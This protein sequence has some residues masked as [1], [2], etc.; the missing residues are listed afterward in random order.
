MVQNG[1]AMTDRCDQE[2]TNEVLASANLGRSIV[3][4]Q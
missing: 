3:Q 4:N 2:K 1:L